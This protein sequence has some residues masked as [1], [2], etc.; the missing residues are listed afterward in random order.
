MTDQKKRG[1]HPP[2][3]AVYGRQNCPCRQR[4]HRRSAILGR[5][6]CHRQGGLRGRRPDR[7]S[8]SGNYEQVFKT[9][10]ID[11][12]N[13]KSA[14]RRRQSAAGTRWYPD[15][16]GACGQSALRYH[17]RRGIHLI[18]R[19]GRRDLARA[20]RAKIPNL[21]AIYA[22]FYD[23][24]PADTAKFGIPFGGG[25]TMLL[26]HNAVGITDN[27]WKV[28]WDDRLA[29]KT[30]L[31]GTAWWWSLS[32]PAVMRPFADLDEMWDYPKGTEPL[33]QELEKLKV[34]LVQGRRRQ[35]HPEPG[36][37][38]RQ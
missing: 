21:A 37:G 34:P 33:F 36:R 17:G 32:V 2:Q 38:T 26:V 13:E 35:A 31:D 20:G 18:E 12:F 24:R 28:S 15:Q 19:H 14:P 5:A 27:S 9:E 22:W 10:V 1:L 6:P 16:G 23:T 7:G 30:T 3:N 25:T 8:W 4:R 29:K 11:P